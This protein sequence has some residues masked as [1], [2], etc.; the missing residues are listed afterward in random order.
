MQKN[1]VKKLETAI[2]KHPNY[3]MQQ[4]GD[5][6]GVSKQRVHQL[7]GRLTVP[8]ESKKCCIKISLSKAEVKRLIRDRLT[9]KEIRRTTGV[10]PHS[11]RQHLDY[12]GLERSHVMAKKIPLE[13]LR[14]YIVAHPERTIM[15]I[16]THFG[17]HFTAIRSRI[18]RNDLPYIKKSR[19]S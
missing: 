8:Y 5:L 4:L 7:L 1:L 9:L 10:G 2:K 19:K 16:A 12:Y 18:E 17:V 3:S 15:E 11:F 6:L 13:N 14:K